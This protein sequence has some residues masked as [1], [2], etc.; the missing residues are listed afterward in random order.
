M[1]QKQNKSINP[2]SILLDGHKCGNVFD[3]SNWNFR[4]NFYKF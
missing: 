2:S 4:P 1:V 3:Q